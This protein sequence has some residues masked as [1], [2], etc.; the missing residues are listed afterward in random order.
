MIVASQWHA[1]SKSEPRSPSEERTIVASKP[2][3]YDAAVS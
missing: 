2:E 3:K 1:F